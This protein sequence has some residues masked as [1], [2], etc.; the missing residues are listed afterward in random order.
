MGKTIRCYSRLMLFP[1]LVDEFTHSAAQE[2]Q[3]AKGIRHLV[4]RKRSKE[5]EWEVPVLSS[6][7]NPK[8]P[9]RMQSRALLLL[10]FIAAQKNSS[11]FVSLPSSA[12]AFRNLGTSSSRRCFTRGLLTMNSE[13]PNRRQALNAAGKLALLSGLAFP[14]R[15]V[16]GGMHIFGQQMPFREAFHTKSLICSR[17]RTSKSCDPCMPCGNKIVQPST[18]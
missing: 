14:L 5:K 18:C 12:G 16:H 15:Y 2:K 6:R 1:V 7:G 8:N 4:Q 3:S 17:L 13:Q 10:V 11:A 9:P